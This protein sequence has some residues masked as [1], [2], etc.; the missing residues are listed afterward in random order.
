MSFAPVAQ[1][2]A[3]KFGILTVYKRVELS[4]S[5]IPS[6]SSIYHVILPCQVCQVSQEPLAAA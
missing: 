3:K 2:L 6:K 1:H 5:S 4:A